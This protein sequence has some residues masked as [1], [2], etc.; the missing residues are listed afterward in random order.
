ML[1]IAHQEADRFICT[2]KSFHGGSKEREAPY[3]LRA[4]ILGRL[5][6]TISLRISYSFKHISFA[7]ISV[8]SCNCERDSLRG[9]THYIRWLELFE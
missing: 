1:L 4:P 8:G 3:G 6:E 9:D 2:W 5:I 7:K